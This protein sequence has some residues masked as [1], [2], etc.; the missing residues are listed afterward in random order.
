MFSSCPQKVSEIHGGNRL[1][2]KRIIFRALFPETLSQKTRKFSPDGYIVGFKKD[3]ES[4]IQESEEK[5]GV[6]F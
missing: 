3:S 2:I 6:F 4:G 5:E 1:Y